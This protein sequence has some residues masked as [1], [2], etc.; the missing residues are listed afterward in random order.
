[1][2]IE[3]ADNT[4]NAGESLHSGW[5]KYN[6]L[7]TELRAA[8]FLLK[9]AATNFT[10]AVLHK[11]LTGA[12][13]HTPKAHT[14]GSHSTKAHTELTG[15]AANQHHNE[16]HTLASH[17]TK[18]HAELTGVSKD[19]HHNEDHKARHT[20][21]SDDVQNATAAQKGLATATQITKL[22]G[23]EA[24]AK[25]NQ[26]GAEILALFEALS[27]QAWAQQFNNLLKNGSFESWSAGAAAPP[28]GWSFGG[29][30]AVI[31]REATIIRFGEY[32]AKF[33]RN[34]ND[35]YFWQK[36]IMIDADTNT[37]WWGRKVIFGMW[38]WASVVNRARLRYRD[39][40]D[41]QYSDYHPGDS[42]WHFLTLPFTVNP[43]A[44]YIEIRGYIDT[45]D[46]DVYFDGAILVEGTICPTF[47]PKFQK[48]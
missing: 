46:T 23:I 16:T 41:A 13:L 21:G 11:D 18:A 1:M 6:A 26:T 12:D 34:G 2:A 10:A 44:T 42:A 4:E 15:V 39:G 20:D 29:G 9:S 24:N 25:D 47:A 14:L 48:Q 32:S 22:D 35:C 8:A 28:D 45:G 7:I 43:T 30:G 36:P 5:A 40:V 3:Q 33:T 27:A 19:Q 31:A 37:Y 38:V 17:S